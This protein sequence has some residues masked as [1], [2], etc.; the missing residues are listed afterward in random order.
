MFV[1]RTCLFFLLCFFAPFFRQEVSREQISL[2][3]LL[4][5]NRYEFSVRD[6]EISGPGASFLKRLLSEPQFVAIGEE[7]GTR[8]VP[9]FIWATCRSMATKGLDA[10]AIEEGPLV[11]EK[12]RQWTSEPDGSA[13]LAAF[14][15]QYPNSIAFF[16]WQQEF[17]LLSHCE[18]TTVP[19]IVHLWGLDQEFLGMPGFILH[20]ILASHPGLKA[21]TMA[22]K[23]LLQ[24]NSDRQE[25]LASGSWNDS[26][27]FRLSAAD[28]ASLQ[29]AL[30]RGG[31]R[32]EQ[33]LIAALIKTQHIY[34]EHEG[35]HRYEANRERSLLLKH[36]FIT[37]YQQPSKAKPH[38]RV[39]LK[40]GGNHLYKGFDESNLND[41]GN[42]VSE[43]ADGLGSSS[44]H[45]EIL[46]IQGEHE[47]QFGPGASDK[48]V[49][50][51]AGADSFATLQSQMMLGVGSS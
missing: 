11:T 8:E 48:A 46:G 1:R 40:F 3:Q 38:P 9:Q 13:H 20:E 24:C 49:A 41:L 32:R 27:M 2:D 35:G 28:L 16:Y 18:Q 50:I 44:L 36:N 39:L 30:V 17:D 21:T 29:N 10:M 5:E 37:D 14:E 23:L 25:S 33:Q 15:R 19:R 12:L 31:N 7:H 43:V 42:F 51:E 6:G 4:R 26:C 47:Q 22:N 34:R 45:I